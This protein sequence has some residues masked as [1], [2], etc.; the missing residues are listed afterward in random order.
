MIFK[1]M[2]QIV[3]IL[4]NQEESGMVKDLELLIN[5]LLDLINNIYPIRKGNY[6]LNQKFINGR[7]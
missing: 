5:T 7:I 6:N 2:R 3:K 4:F 1:F